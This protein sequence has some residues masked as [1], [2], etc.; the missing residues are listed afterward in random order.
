MSY[1]DL[2]WPLVIG[3]V[4]GKAAS[5][6]AMAAP[7]LTDVAR[8]ERQSWRDAPPCRIWWMLPMVGPVLARNGGQSDK[9]FA[10]A[11]EALALLVPLWATVAG[12]GWPYWATCL[13]GWALLALGA[14]DLRHLLLPDILTLPLI[15]VGLAGAWTFDGAVFG[16]HVIG[17][18][19]GF[20]VLATI[21]WTYERLRGREGIGLGDAKLLAAA[22]AWLGWPALP[23]V[24]LI[25]TVAGSATFAVMAARR[26]W[27]LETPVPFGVFIAGA[28]WLVWLYGPLVTR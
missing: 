16:D 3:T 19:A 25:S 14:T 28:F 27:T 18:V 12:V 10:V 20:G 22:G 1:C 8:M 5:A 2:M 11:I 13:L 15:G 4:A 17:A 26:R 6:V 23:G 9:A 7:R 21:G 24:V